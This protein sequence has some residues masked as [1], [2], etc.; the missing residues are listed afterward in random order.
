MS[1]GFLSC[2]SPERRAHSRPRLSWKAAVAWLTALIV[3][4][5][6][7][8]AGVA[9][10]TSVE[11]SKL[12]A[13]LEASPIATCDDSLFETLASLGE[14]PNRENARR[15]VLL[16]SALTLR[17][18]NQSSDALSS[19]I[20]SDLTTAMGYITDAN[21]EC[22]LESARR[23]AIQNLYIRGGEASVA[24]LTAVADAQSPKLSF[25]VGKTSPDLIEWAFSVDRIGDL[26]DWL[27]LA[28]LCDLAS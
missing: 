20:D 13:C 1:R 26:H 4:G 9:I 21:S 3:M 28:P 14:E 25:L 5:I 2:S 12:I 6:L 15:A 7:V 23:Y 16:V 11:T 18:A 22:H 24:V 27:G 17:E 19:V 10:H 8:S